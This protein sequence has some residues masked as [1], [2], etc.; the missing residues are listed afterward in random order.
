MKIYI[1]RLLMCLCVMLGAVSISTSGYAKSVKTP[2]TEEAKQSLTV[3]RPKE[4]TWIDITL[5]K[6]QPLDFLVSE[7]T[8]YHVKSSLNLISGEIGTVSLGLAKLEALQRHRTAYDPD[9]NS[10]PES[11]I[12]L[13]YSK[14]KKTENWTY[15]PLGV[16]QNKQRFLWN[17]REF[18]TRVGANGDR[19]VK[20]T[21]NVISTVNGVWSEHHEN[22]IYL[23]LEFSNTGETSKI[24]TTHEHPFYVPTNRTWVPASDLK[25]GMSL[26]TCNGT[27]VRVKDWKVVD[28]PFTAY[29][30]EVANSH[31]YFVADNENP[32]LPSVLV[33]N[34]CERSKLLG[35]GG[36]QLDADTIIGIYGTRYRKKADGTYEP[37]V[38]ENG[39]GAIASADEI[40]RS[41]VEL[42]YDNIS[43]ASP[44]QVTTPRNL[45]EQLLWDDVLDNPLADATPLTSNDGRFFD[46]E[47]KQKT[48]LSE[49]G[50]RVTIH[51][52][53]N[54]STGRVVDI[55]ITH[56]PKT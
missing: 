20:P 3:Y 30:F 49:N 9:D 8:A 12:Q 29:N 55:K 52:Q 44:T 32:N 10:Y 46:F 31:T 24:I 47:K 42:D 43:T 2:V 26:E 51:Y 40:K 27:A 48:I 38:N 34:S 11:D 45:Q 33:H 13:V 17:G 53:Y 28:E 39:R 5:D 41:R 21:G 15:Q 35:P 7:G 18:I 56:P 25:I 14:W 6:L 4:N 16:M 19:S 1:F 22:Q 37:D 36:K 50:E 54:P 23:T